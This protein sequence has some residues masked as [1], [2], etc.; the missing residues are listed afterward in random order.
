MSSFNAITYKLGV[1]TNGSSLPGTDYISAMV[2]YNASVPALWPTTGPSANVVKCYSKQDAINAGLDGLH[3][4]ETAAAATVLITAVGATGDVLNIYSQELYGPPVLLCS[5]VQKS[6]DTT[7][8]ILAASMVVAINANKANNGGYSATSSTGTITITFRPGL[9][10]IP[11]T[12]TPISTVATS[13]STFAVTI[14]Q[15]TGSSGTTLGVGSKWD[16]YYYHIHQYFDNNPGGILYVGIFPVVY[17]F[18]ELQTIMGIA[19]SANGPQYNQIGVY[20]DGHTFTTADIT[21][22]EAIKVSMS[23]NHTPISIL[24]QGDIHATADIGSL[25]NL[26][27]LSGT[28]IGVLCGQDGQGLGNLLYN[29]YGKS[30]G[31]L[32]AAMGVFS[33]GSVSS[34]F[35]QPIQS[36]NISTTA[37]GFPICVGGVITTNSALE[38]SVPA[39]ANGQLFQPIFSTAGTKLTQLDNYR[40]IY[41][42]LY[43]G[44]TGTYFSEN[45]TCT[46][47]NASIAYL[48]D[49]RVTNKIQRLLYPAYL[50]YLKSQI[51][52]TNTGAIAPTMI[53]VL[54]SAGQ[55]ALNVM[56]TNDEL[57]ATNVIIN[58]L[59]NITTSGKLVVTLYDVEN[60]IARNIEIDINTVSAIPTV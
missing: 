55:N 45:Q 5:Y 41:I 59:Q 25:V 48:N 3:E 57:S 35:A 8:T 24:L 38:N 1:S 31:N 56:L 22:L 58:P 43:P 53:P 50:P 27:G 18:T 16:I 2:F 20:V 12:G 15:P 60:A 9:G 21:T 6:T 19:T 39:F 14:T 10:V 49:D 42:G 51:T 13:G 29:A 17:T 47:S 52:L 23:A 40:W 4:D 11:N 37:I 54:T 46:L 7:A 32:G 28:G 33:L 30:V 44:Y 26:S 34:D 36:N